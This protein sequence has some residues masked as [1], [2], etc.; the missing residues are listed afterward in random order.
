MVSIVFENIYFI[1][2]AKLNLDSEGI[3]LCPA[4]SPLTLSVEEFHQHFG[5]VFID[6]TGYINLCANVTKNTFQRVSLKFLSVLKVDGT[7]GTSLSV[8]DS[9]KY[10]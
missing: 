9:F 4:S 8:F 2:P 1:F 3:S 6:S 7:D 10:Y 5:V